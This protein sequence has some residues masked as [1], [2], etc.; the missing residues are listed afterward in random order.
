MIAFWLFLAVLFEVG[1]AVAMKLSQGFSKLG[2]TIAT[3][4]MYL[5]SVLF[6][7]LATKR[8]DIG[9]AYAIWAGSGVALIAIAGMAYFKEP[10][11][12]MKIASIA[13]IVVG[14]VGLQV[15]SGGH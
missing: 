14:I 10:A 13:V 15:S 9:V 3:I 12:A 4:V 5:L 11:S 6:L 2:P 7:A 8:M 1:W